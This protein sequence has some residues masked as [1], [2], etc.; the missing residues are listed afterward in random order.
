VKTGET[1]GNG[2]SNSSSSKS[3]D[4]SILSERKAFA[5]LRKLKKILFSKLTIY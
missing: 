3:L 2:I 5:Q 1:V 4:E